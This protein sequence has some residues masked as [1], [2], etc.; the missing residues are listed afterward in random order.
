MQVKAGN[1][2][3]ANSLIQGLLISALF[4]P[5]GALCSAEITQ[6]TEVA[7]DTA[8]FEF[9]MVLVYDECDP[10]KVCAHALK[11]IPLLPFGMHM[12]A[13]RPLMSCR[14]YQRRCKTRLS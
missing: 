3:P 6:V 14:Q 12:Y 10:R 1:I 13:L 9:S 4:E 8:L 5:F 11:L 7:L 2:L